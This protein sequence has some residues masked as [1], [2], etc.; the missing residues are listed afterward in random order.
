MIS[1][2][3]NACVGE[4]S[5]DIH[6][7]KSFVGSVRY[8]QEAA[9]SLF[10][11][12]KKRFPIV[13]FI[14]AHVAASYPVPVFAQTSTHT[15]LGNDV[16]VSEDGGKTT[17]PAKYFDQ[18]DPLTLEDMIERIPGV[19]IADS[20]SNGERRGLRGTQG[21]ILIN[22]QQV[23]GKDNDASSA[24]T[25]IIASQVQYVKIM[26]RSSS[27]VQSTTQR[28]INVVLTDDAQS[29]MQVQAALLWYEGDDSV[30]FNPTLIYSANNVRNNY[31]VFLR[32]VANARPWKRTKL[33]TDLDGSPILNSDENEQLATHKMRAIG[34]YEQNF[35]SGSRLQMSSYIEGE[36]ID[37]ERREVEDDPSSIG[38]PMRLSDIL[39]D[40]E[41]DIWTAEFSADY[42]RPLG[43]GDSVTVLGF[44]NWEEEKR[45][46]E[47]FELFGPIDTVV[48]R[49]ARKDVKTESVV[50]ATY[51]W[52]EN[53]RLGVQIGAEGT[54]NTQK[55]D[56][57]LSNRVGDELVAQPVF[58]SNGKVTEYR[59]EFFSTAR[60]RHT[61]TLNSEFGMAIEASRISQVG[62]V[63]GSRTISYVK[64]SLS[65]FWNV[66]P[67]DRLYL[68]VIR[69]VQQLNF[70]EF[71]ATITDR[72]Q[73]LE[74]GNP[75]LR[76]ERS[77]DATI[78]YEHGLDNGAG[79]LTLSGFY[80]HV[81]DVSGRILFQDSITQPGNIGNGS[82]IGAEVE[83]SL[84][85][86]RLGWW[87]GILTTKYLYR[88]T[89]VTDPFIGMERNFDQNPDWEFEISYRHD[90]N[91]LIDGYV[92][93]IYR[94]NGQKHIFDFDYIESI[95]EAGAW[96]VVVTHQ[97][98]KT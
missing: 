66:A 6:G 53:P 10:G 47:V 5:E 90:I 13:L 89:S 15:T 11:L 40:D 44:F 98:K 51:D 14:V 72:D 38:G 55:T 80:R 41:R 67:S 75:D 27:E 59:G 26:R 7:L 25:Q 33:T 56:F 42:S 65:T 78:G 48:T 1:F 29:V 35:E 19:S 34:R 31:S 73:E 57:E 76:P 52:T 88:D 85:F 20:T 3:R 95:K 82:E 71:V 45:D 30:R 74:A 37:R 92:D 9:I 91:T 93:L 63:S 50:R 69:D 70:L 4:L 36:L 16:V 21:A 32:S 28:I 83:L 64:P 46:R 79:L 86:T 54:L 62:D 8:L 22:G 43:Q 17:Y 18:F 23:I 2:V 97:L 12:T 96:T 49:Q 87:D 77:W 39:E 60:W 61:G 24:L 94:E 58:N 84:Q 81:E 68:S